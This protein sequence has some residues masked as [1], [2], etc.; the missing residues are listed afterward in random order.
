MNL[1]RLLRARANNPVRVGIIGCGKFSSMFLAQAQRTVGMHVVGIADRD[2]QRAK[3]SLARVGWPSERYSAASLAEAVASSHHSTC[4][5]ED[6]EELIRLP[7]LD[8]VV[9]ATGSPP[10]GIRH[11]LTA[12]EHG[13]HL[14]MVNVETDALVGPL[15]AQRAHAA[16]LVY[17]LAY[18]DQPALIAE[19]VDW[20]RACAA[21]QLPH[22]VPADVIT[23]FLPGC[24]CS[25]TT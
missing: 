11:A 25:A 4:I 16:G 1:Y 24:A 7:E 6:T 14:V 21:A 19:I 22:T 2:V 8:V 12:I 5:I 15:L 10:A 9:D 20:A 23:R 13:K 3:Q 18:G 17:S